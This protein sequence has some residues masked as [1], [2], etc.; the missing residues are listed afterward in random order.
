MYRFSICASVQKKKPDIFHQTGSD[1]VFNKKENET[2]RIHYKIY[3]IPLKTNA[4]TAY[5]GT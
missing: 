4:N 3:R 5:R 1:K 2:I